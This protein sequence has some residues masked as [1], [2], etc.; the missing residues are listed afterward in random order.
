M[1][2]KA[3]RLTE[4]MLWA[5]IRPWLNEYG[6]AIRLESFASGGVPDVLWV[7]RKGTHLLELKIQHGN[8]IKLQPWQVAFHAKLYDQGTETWFVVAKGT[9]AIA[10]VYTWSFLRDLPRGSVGDKVVIDM[11]D[12]RASHT[13]ITKKDID[14]WTSMM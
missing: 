8:Q 12:S 3:P 11:T 13:L 10:L 9:T 6:T 7:N 2:L 1:K 5:R 4:K 14:F